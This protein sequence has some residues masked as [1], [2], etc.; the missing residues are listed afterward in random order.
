MYTIYYGSEFVYFS[1]EY[2][3]QEQSFDLFFD[4]LLLDDYHG[5]LDELNPIAK[6]MQIIEEFPE[7]VKNIHTCEIKCSEET[8]LVFT[9]GLIEHGYIILGDEIKIIYRA[10]LRKLEMLGEL[11][12]VYP[13]IQY[14]GINKKLFHWFHKNKQ[15]GLSVIFYPLLKECEKEEEKENKN[16]K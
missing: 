13:L 2:K 8:L 16:E 11:K 10:Y 4:K 6:Y 14:T 7:N 3:K 5:S 1:E 9:R 12:S 15:V